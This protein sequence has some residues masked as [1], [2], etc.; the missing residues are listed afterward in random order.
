MSKLKTEV[1]CLAAFG[2]AGNLLDAS[3]KWYGKLQS[4]SQHNHTHAHKSEDNYFEDLM[5]GRVMTATQCSSTE[6]FPA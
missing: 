1:G 4:K 2:D 6:V 3:R 5:C